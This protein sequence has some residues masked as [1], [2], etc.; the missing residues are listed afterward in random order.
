MG[1]ANCNAIDDNITLTNT[2]K[3]S[4]I[5]DQSFVE[6]GDMVLATT[7]YTC[8]PSALA[9]VLM[10]MGF[11][12]NEGEIAKQAGTDETGTSLQGLKDTAKN[13]IDV[14]RI[15]GAKDVRIDQLK[16]YNIV[17]LNIDDT[18]H[19]VVYISNT[20][21]I[22]T[23]FDPNLGVLNMTMD[24]FSEFYNAGG[25]TILIIN[26]TLH[27]DATLLSP[28]E[29]RDIKA[30]SHLSRIGSWWEPPKIWVSWVP[31]SYNFSV[32]YLAYRWVPGYT[33]GYGWASVTVRGYNWP[34]IAWRT[35]TYHFYLPVLHYIP[36][37]GILSTCGF[38][39]MMKKLILKKQLLKKK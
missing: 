20:T 32:P 25:Q 19:F 33:I 27:K 14:N 36:G 12:T 3:D 26:G 23:V 11:Y 10:H 7:I 30:L 9:T 5:V 28:D 13:W 35:V 39:M 21:T 18:N 15:I 4:Y 29:M 1:I 34:Y 16:P 37:S 31:A 22:I 17:V 24:K 8:G 2:F 6:S 38:L